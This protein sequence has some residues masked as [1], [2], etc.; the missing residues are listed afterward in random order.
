MSHTYI[1]THTQYKCAYNHAHTLIDRTEN[2]EKMKKTFNEMDQIE[3]VVTNALNEDQLS[4][5][6]T[7]LE[8]PFKNDIEVHVH[9][10]TITFY[11][12]AQQM[13]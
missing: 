11:A 12:Y 5:L 9:A 7:S 2:L 4:G 10:I 1:C 3:C 8:A 13:P 6:E